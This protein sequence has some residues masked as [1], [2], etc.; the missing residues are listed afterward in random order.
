MIQWSLSTHWELGECRGP[1]LNNN[2][3]CVNPFLSL[4]LQG[5]LARGDL[6]G[7]QVEKDDH[8]IPA[9]RLEDN[10]FLTS[11]HPH[12]THF[13]D[14][15][16]HMTDHLTHYVMADGPSSLKD[17]AQSLQPANPA[18]SELLLTNQSGSLHPH[19][20]LPA[21]P[22]GVVDQVMPR[23][24]SSQNKMV[25]TL[26]SP[27]NHS[28]AATT[29]MTVANRSPPPPHHHQQQQ[30]YHHYHNRHGNSPGQYH[31]SSSMS[32]LG[33]V[34]DDRTSF[35]EPPTSSTSSSSFLMRSAPNLVY[36]K[37]SSTRA[38][39]YPSSSS[40]PAPSSTSSSSE[41]GVIGDF[42]GSGRRRSSTNRPPMQKSLSE[43]TPEA[44]AA[45][46]LPRPTSLGLIARGGGSSGEGVTA[47]G[48]ASMA[49]EGAQQQL[50]MCPNCKKT[51]PTR[52]RDGFE[53]WF[54]HIK[55]C[56]V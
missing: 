30:Q 3:S 12:P 8:P 13:S 1:F 56:S 52:T 55:T 2:S 34:S 42:G 50:L 39:S 46:M 29:M 32:S 53:L 47:V 28:T 10:V 25:P 35:S 43:D 5:L 11:S 31:T 49:R 44:Q 22:G 45:Q 6:R 23:P 21:I 40:G 16:G 37:P 54:E 51:M 27:S 24:P 17:N 9:I 4:T 38:G 26:L 41:E 20:S 19:T 48:V 15:R 18:P 33:Y 14:K 7:G 36:Y